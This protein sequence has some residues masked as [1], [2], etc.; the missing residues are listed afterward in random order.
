VVL[1]FSTVNSNELNRNVMANEPE[2][3]DG[4]LYS[5]G[6]SCAALGEAWDGRLERARL[7]RLIGP[8]ISDPEDVNT[9]HQSLGNLLGGLPPQ[10]RPC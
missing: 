10:A 9:T 1:V 3:N 8:C 5:G 4:I 7:P 2:H 6:N